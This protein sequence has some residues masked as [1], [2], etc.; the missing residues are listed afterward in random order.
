MSHRNRPFGYH[1]VT[2][3][4]AVCGKRLSAP[5]WDSVRQAYVHAYDCSK[6]KGR[7]SSEERARLRREAGVE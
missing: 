7:P 5:M 2:P 4:C 6:P 1:S 3:S